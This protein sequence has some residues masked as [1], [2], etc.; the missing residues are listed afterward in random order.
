LQCAY[1]DFD[2]TGQQL[3]EAS[4]ILINGEPV[5]LDLPVAEG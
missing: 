3:L 4:F 1:A 5:S 2:A